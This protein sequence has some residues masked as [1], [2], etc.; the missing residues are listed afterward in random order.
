MAAALLLVDDEAILL[1]SMRQELRLAFG[2][3]F[4]YETAL[5][6]EQ[7][8]EAIER[9]AERGIQVA[10]VI[11]DWLMPGMRGDEFLKKVH[12]EHPS[13]KLA[14]LSGHAGDGQMA[15]LKEE[16]GLV[17]FLA[18]PYGRGNLASMIREAFPQGE[19]A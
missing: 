16:A 2:D 9:L 3:A 19:S 7:G 12:S 4:I 14:M 13:V 10:M 1:L 18:K 15:R 11:S 6:A 5:S 17:A 8:L